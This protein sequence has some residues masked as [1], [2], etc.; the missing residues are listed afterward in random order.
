M[1]A[2]TSLLLIFLAVA[3]AA[4]AAAT[5]LVGPRKPLAVIAPTLAAVVALYLVGHRL[6]LSAGPSVR[7][8]GFQ[9]SLLFDVAVALAAAFVTAAAQRV[10]AARSRPGGRRREAP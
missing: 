4:G 5:G 9:V 2:A 6:S 8:F 1:N 10:V 3:L 7:L